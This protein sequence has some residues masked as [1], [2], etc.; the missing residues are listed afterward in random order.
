[1]KPAIHHIGIYAA[2]LCLAFAGPVGASGEGGIITRFESVVID[3]SEAGYRFSVKMDHN[4]A[5][6]LIEVDWSG[7]KFSFDKNDFGLVSRVYM[8]GIRM[9]AS[10]PYS[11]GKQD[12]VI[13]VLP[14]NVKLV[15]NDKDDT[16]RYQ[17][18]VVRLR[19][20]KGK[21]TG[22]EKAESI[23]GKQGKWKLTDKGEIIS[24]VVNGINKVDANGVHD[25][26]EE[27]WPNN[28]YSE[29]KIYEDSP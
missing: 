26:G 24:H 22:W 4:E 25:N 29:F 19:F 1:M 18:D 27:S 7:K 23:E 17:Y 5:L 21:L 2:I 10:T 13:M 20:S 16:V 12:T 15:D 28:P 3:A 6:K 9:V 11:T 8:R 14:Y